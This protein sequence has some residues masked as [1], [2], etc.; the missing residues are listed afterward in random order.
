M[1]SWV[2]KCRSQAETDRADTS[3]SASSLVG[4]V[5]NPNMICGL[6]RLLGIALGIALAADRSPLIYSLLSGSEQKSDGL[7]YNPEFALVAQWV[8]A[9]SARI[10]ALSLPTPSLQARHVVRISFRDSTQIVD[11]QRTVVGASCRLP[12]HLRP[13]GDRPDPAKPS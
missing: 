11:R 13:N 2:G 7:G 5:R 9:A 4:G 10:P 6:R 8:R 12:C 1:T 3:A